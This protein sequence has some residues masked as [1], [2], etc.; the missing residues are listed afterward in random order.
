MAI[1]LDGWFLIVQDSV[2]TKNKDADEKM[3]KLDSEF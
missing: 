3:N 2:D 1:K